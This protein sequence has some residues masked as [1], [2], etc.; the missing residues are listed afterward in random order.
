M[1]LVAACREILESDAM[2]PHAYMPP[3]I[4]VTLESV[5]IKYLFLMAVGEQREFHRELIHFR[6]NGDF[7]G[8]EGSGV[9]DFLLQFGT[10]EP[11]GSVVY[12]QVGDHQSRIFCAH[13]CQPFVGFECEKSFL[14]AKEHF[15]AIAAR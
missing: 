7:S 2:L 6:W 9:K 13:G 15:A 14:A 11:E 5:L 12:Q 8:H 1:Q 3:M 4:I 10:D